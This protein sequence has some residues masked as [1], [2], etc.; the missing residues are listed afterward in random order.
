MTAVVALYTSS[1]VRSKSMLSSS[2]MSTPS[3]KTKDSCKTQKTVCGRAGSSYKTTQ[4][5]GCTASHQ[6]IGPISPAGNKKRIVNPPAKQQCSYWPTLQ[7]AK[8]PL[9]FPPSPEG[10]RDPPS[11]IMCLWSQK[12]S[13]S[14]RTSISSAVFAQLSSETCSLTD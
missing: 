6:W 10:D 2:F 1:L 4:C 11:N 3:Y 8:F 12:V 5:I 7:W 9:T 13:I 14:K